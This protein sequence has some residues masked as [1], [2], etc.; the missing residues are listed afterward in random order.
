MKAL[1]VAAISRGRHKQICQV[2]VG[3]QADFAFGGAD[4]LENPSS[5]G[6]EPRRWSH[7][8]KMRAFISSKTDLA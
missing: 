4:L 1:V 2:R 6:E 5:P 8:R 7:A 3:A